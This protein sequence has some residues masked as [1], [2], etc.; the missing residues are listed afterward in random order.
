MAK[1]PQ[2]APRL[3]NSTAIYAAINAAFPSI[4]ADVVHKRELH[5][6]HIKPVQE[7]I[8]AAFKKLSADTGIHGAELR[9][10]FKLYAREQD[11]EGFED[12]DDRIKVR[13][14]L[15]LML[16]AMVQ[17]KTWGFLDVLEDAGFKT[18]R[19]KDAEAAKNAG[20]EEEKGE[21]AKVL[22][23]PGSQARH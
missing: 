2:S 9:A 16:G 11:A 13:D 23:G 7:N 18:Q 3:S 14:G 20:K 5:E 17:G 10:F 21:G 15:R 12:D 4:L 6:E 8:T 1:G 19:M 22:A